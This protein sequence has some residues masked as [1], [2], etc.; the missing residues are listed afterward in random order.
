MINRARTPGNREEDKEPRSLKYETDLEL[1]LT[2]KKK[3]ID[4]VTTSDLWTN[5]Y[6]AN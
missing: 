1:I 4:N 3:K 5:Y 6:E 2:I